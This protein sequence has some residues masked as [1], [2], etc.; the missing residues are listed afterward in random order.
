MVHRSCVAHDQAAAVIHPPKAPLDLPA[1]AVAWPRTDRAPA[2]GTTSVA[3]YEGR[4]RG[5]D[6]PPAQLLAEDLAV[7][8]SVC[9][10]FL[11]PRARPPSPLWHLNRGQRG[12]GQP[13]LVWLGAG[14]RQPNGQA[15]AVRNDHDFGAFT[16]V[17][18]A[19]ARSPCFAGTKL[20]SRK[21]CAHSSLP[22]AS[23]WLNSTRCSPPH[24]ILDLSAQ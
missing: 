24:N 19:D 22:W 9:D 6:P 20:P 16:H 8:G 17:G 21:A 13:T 1:L 11:R 7:V 2:L 3:A 12:L 23:N 5:F 15:M 14:Y 4:D 18:L 10:Q